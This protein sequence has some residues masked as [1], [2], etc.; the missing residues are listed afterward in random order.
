[1]NIKSK[2]E[3][4]AG[5][6]SVD[7]IS[8]P[9]GHKDFGS[10]LTIYRVLYCTS[11]P[12]CVGPTTGQYQLGCT[13]NT[14]LSLQK[15]LLQCSIIAKDFFPPQFYF[16]V[17]MQTSDGVHLISKTKTCRLLSNSKYIMIYTDK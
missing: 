9:L 16:K 11:G 2:C 17:E 12:P 6:K 15:E 8:L 10:N 4:I 5:F 1:M 7:I 14:S 3:G 13:V